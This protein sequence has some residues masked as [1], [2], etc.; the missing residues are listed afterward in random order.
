MMP[1]SEQ[2]KC[3]ARESS[4]VS[5]APFGCDIHTHTIFSRHAYS[6][7]G[8]CVAAARATGLELL[9]STD[10]YSAMIS[11]TTPN[12]PA[13]LRDYQHFINFSVWPREWDGVYVMRG[14]EADIVDLDGH[15]FGWDVVL[16]EGITGRAFAAPKTLKDKVWQEIDYAIASI[17][18]ETF[19]K[20]ATLAQTTGMYIRALEDSK[21]VALGHPGR[22]GVP[23]EVDPVLLA[24]KDLGKLIE[25]NEHSFAPRY[26]RR[27]KEA[28]RRI[29]E[30]CAELGV[31]ISVA[32]DAHIACDVGRFDAVAALLNEIH[33]PRTLV[34]TRDA[35]TF[36]AVLQDAVAA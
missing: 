6:T 27:R 25:I 26:S 20:G 17:H 7:I 5:A 12:N 19:T 30:R 11:A 34:A 28:C 9:G 32:T 29:A 10:H 18:D 2:T 13:Y 36:R 35:A 1:N 3:N 15:L 31:M 24:A 33:F 8:E 14:V 21:V 23:F 22:A 4:A 16:R